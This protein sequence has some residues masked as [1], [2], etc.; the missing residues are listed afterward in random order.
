VKGRIN[1]CPRYEELLIL[2]DSLVLEVSVVEI[3]GLK[4]HILVLRTCVVLV[5][6]YSIES[7][8]LKPE[9]VILERKRFKNLLW[10]LCEPI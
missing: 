1:Y 7:L 5:S 2:H 4:V 10:Q 6:L 3:A 8:N 9:L